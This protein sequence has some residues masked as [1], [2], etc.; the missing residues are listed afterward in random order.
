VDHPEAWFLAAEKRLVAFRLSALSLGI[1][2]ANGPTDIRGITV[3]RVFSANFCMATDLGGVKFY[4]VT[5]LKILFFDVVRNKSSVKGGLIQSNIHKPKS[6]TCVYQVRKLT[7]FL[8]LG[9]SE[10]NLTRE[11]IKPG[12]KICPC[13]R[14]P[15]RPYMHHITNHRGFPLRQ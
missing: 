10:L 3:G 7:T 8:G 4:D 6:S 2:R 12:I 5:V 9:A 15:V 14:I 13:S 11:N 1:F